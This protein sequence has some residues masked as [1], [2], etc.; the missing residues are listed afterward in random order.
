MGSHTRF[1]AGSCLILAPVVQA[2]ST[3]FW[4]AH[5]QGITTGTLILLATV[6]WIVGLARVFHDIEGRVPRYAAVAFPMAVYGCLGGAS[7]G[8]QGMYEELFGVSHADAVRVV[9]EHPVPAFLTLWVAGVLFPTSMAV[10]G[11]VLARIRYVPP[12][13][14]ILMV[15]G[16]LFFPLSRIPREVVVAHLADLVLILP[17]AHIGVL[18]LTARRTADAPAPSAPLR[19]NHA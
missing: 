1:I 4:Q 18:M 12:P 5:R 9:G 7:F 3:F 8:L 14:G 19:T 16:A 13:T 10:L 17:F 2:T 6:L 11:V 15:V